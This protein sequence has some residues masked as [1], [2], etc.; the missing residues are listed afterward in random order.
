LAGG[1]LD[2]S[3]DSYS[4]GSANDVVDEEIFK[5]G[6]FVDLVELGHRF[7]TGEL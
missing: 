5:R 6:E 7:Q 3:S 1:F 4:G 2:C